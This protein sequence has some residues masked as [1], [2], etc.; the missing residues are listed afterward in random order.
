MLTLEDT[1]PGLW[2]D[3]NTELWQR[4]IISELMDDQ[5][6][7]APKNREAELDGVMNFDD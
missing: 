6:K 4:N 7:T 1:Y 2:E 3:L 5:D